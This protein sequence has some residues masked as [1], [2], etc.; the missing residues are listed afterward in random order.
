M[1][2]WLVL[3]VDVVMRVHA[4]ANGT[5]FIVGALLGIWA[6]DIAAYFVGKKFGKHKLCPAVSPGKSIEGLMGG[7]L[8][9]V[10]LAACCWVW[11]VKISIEHALLLALVLVVAGVLGDL[12]ESA[13]KR[14]VGAKDSGRMLPGH[15]GLLDRIDALIP[16][17]VAVGLLWLEIL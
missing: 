3:F 8:F 11:L 12:F 16:S 1:A 13:I 17:L 7:L 10:G 4:H 9:G 5:M 2:I 6:S 15:G 14:M